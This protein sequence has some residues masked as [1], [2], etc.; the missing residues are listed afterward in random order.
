MVL[1]G[2]AVCFCNVMSEITHGMYLRSSELT[3]L[4]FLEPPPPPPPGLSP[5]PYPSDGE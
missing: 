2:F 3:A 5:H 4:K 1:L